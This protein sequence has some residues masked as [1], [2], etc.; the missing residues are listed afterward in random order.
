MGAY[1]ALTGTQSAQLYLLVGIV[2]L[3]I[4]LVLVLSFFLVPN[5]KAQHPAADL[6]V[7]HAGCGFMTSV[8]FVWGFGL[9]R[10]KADSELMHW[11][12]SLLAPFNQFFFLAGAFWYLMLTLDLLVALVNPWMGYS[13]KSRTY[14]TM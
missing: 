12:C 9:P 8:G 14:H 6:V 4:Y 3:V 1:E 2:G 5:I 10:D 7:W 13:C 11:H